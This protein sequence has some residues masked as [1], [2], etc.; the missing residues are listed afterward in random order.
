MFDSEA[1][2]SVVSVQGDEQPE[3]QESA[4]KVPKVTV[5]SQSYITMLQRITGR[6]QLKCDVQH[7]YTVT[8]YAQQGA[9]LYWWAILTVST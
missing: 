2:D 8:L 4:L 7:K 9:I 5:K 6:T 3:K 1:S